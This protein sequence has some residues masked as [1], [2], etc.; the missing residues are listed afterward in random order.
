MA[1]LKSFPKDDF[2]PVWPPGVVP[3][4]LTELGQAFGQSGRRRQQLFDSLTAW[5]GNLKTAGLE[6]RIWV[7]GSFLTDKP[8]PGDIDVVVWPL[9]RVYMGTDTAMIERMLAPKRTLPTAAL[10]IHIEGLGLCESFER[11]A[12]WLGFFGFGWDRRTPRTIA[13]ILIEK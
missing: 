9:G 5:A 8:E 3:T 12:R 2:Q 7:C 13:E 11:E 1:T 6:A 10:D 4:S